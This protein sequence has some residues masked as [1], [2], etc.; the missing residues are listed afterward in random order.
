MLTA[1]LTGI[2]FIVGAFFER[3]VFA[4]M[5][6]LLARATVKAWR[7]LRKRIAHF[8]APLVIRAQARWLRLK[9][10]WRFMFGPTVQVV[11]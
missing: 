2:A 9:R 11:A 6:L 3:I 8:A 5:V 4:V 10:S 7:R 1:L